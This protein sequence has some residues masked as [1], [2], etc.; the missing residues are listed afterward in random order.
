MENFVEKLTNK[1]IKF[2]L[3]NVD[4][5]G[6]VYFDVQ[7]TRAEKFNELSQK[8]YFEAKNHNGRYMTI[9]DKTINL[10][11]LDFIVSGDGSFSS[12]YRENTNNQWIAFMIV[13]FGDKYINILE[14]NSLDAFSIFKHVDRFKKIHDNQMKKSQI[15]DDEFA[16]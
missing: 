8:V 12:D 3:E 5:I 16:E 10:P 2:F 11:N 1:D 14:T 15:H 7:V 13:K 4:N 6:N 9:S